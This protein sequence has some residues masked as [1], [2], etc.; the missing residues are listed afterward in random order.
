[1]NKLMVTDRVNGREYGPNGRDVSSSLACI[2]VMQDA[3]AG[4]RAV[5]KRRDGDSH[6]HRMPSHTNTSKYHIN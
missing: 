5:R 4:E 2:G 1:M 3:S 6:S